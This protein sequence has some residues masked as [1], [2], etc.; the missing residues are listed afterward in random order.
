MLHS[1]CR[2]DES[3]TV[4]LVEAD[5]LLPMS[6]DIFNFA[7]CKTRVPIAC[8]VGIAKSIFEPDWLEI[9]RYATVRTIEKAEDVLLVRPFT[10]DFLRFRALRKAPKRG[11]VVRRHDFE[12]PFLRT[13]LPRAFVVL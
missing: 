11:F 5:K 9:L 8:P 13:T 4:G 10:T 2:I 6:V 7:P 1:F 3:P 12:L